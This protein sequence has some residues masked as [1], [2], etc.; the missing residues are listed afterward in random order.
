M[1]SLTRALKRLLACFARRPGAA[2]EDDEMLTRL[3]LEEFSEKLAAATPTPGGGSAAALAGGLSASLVLMV[4]DLTLGRETYKAHEQAVR[5]IRQRALGLRKDLLALVDKDAQAYD[6][7][8]R[9]LK[10]PKASEAETV[11]RSRALSRANLFA[12][13]TPM[14]TAE[15]CA[16]LMGLAIELARRG[17][18]NA[19][20][21][22]GSAALLAYAGVRAGVMNVRINLKGIKDEEQATKARDRVRRLEVDAERLREEALG[23]T[24]ARMNG[25]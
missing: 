20:S 16:V 13:E 19:V 6:E 10:L 3:T 2:P 22:A 23:A 21:D 17:N 4:C 8:I 15:A 18:A 24:F 12:T 14:A 9:A 7:V 5:T 1:R 11:E 25:R